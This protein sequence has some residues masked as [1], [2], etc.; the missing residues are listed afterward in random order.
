MISFNITTESQPDKVTYVISGYVDEKAAFP[1]PQMRQKII[2]SLKDVV[3][4]N[5]IGTRSWCDWVKQMTLPS[6]VYLDHCP[7]LFVKS[8]NQ[9]IGSLN[10]NMVVNSFLVPYCSSDA[11]EQKNIIFNRG[12][13]YD[14]GGNLCMPKVLDSKGEPMELDVLNQYFKFLKR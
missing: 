3:G 7:L 11:S 14:D 12:S 13:E 6:V 5:S 2:I 4:I 8:F 1:T 9:I 10:S